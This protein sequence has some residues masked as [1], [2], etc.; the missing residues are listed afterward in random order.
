MFLGNGRLSTT[1]KAASQPMKSSTMFIRT[2]TQRRALWQFLDTRKQ[3][4]KS[5]ICSTQVALIKLVLTQ[6][7]L[8]QKFGSFQRLTCRSTCYSY[9]HLSPQFVKISL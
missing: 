8:T 1:S 3:V 2:T 7:A 4:R 5:R 9:S 6:A